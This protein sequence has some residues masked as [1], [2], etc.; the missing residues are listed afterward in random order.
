MLKQSYIV[1]QNANTQLFI[2][3]LE[4]ELQLLNIQVD[5]AQAEDILENMNFTDKNMIIH[6]HFYNK[7]SKELPLLELF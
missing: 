1:S 3:N 2:E 7:K 5:E 6:Y 4:Q